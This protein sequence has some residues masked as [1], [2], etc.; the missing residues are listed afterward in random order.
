MSELI[1]V[2][3]PDE[4]RAAE[5]LQTLRRLQ[6]EGVIELDD[7][8]SA[9]RGRDGQLRL[10]QSHVLTAVSAAQ[11]ALWGG[12]LGLLVLAPLP[13]MVMGAAAGAATGEVKRMGIDGRFMRQLAQQLGPGSSAAFALVRRADPEAV[14]RELRPYGGT[15]LHTTLSEQDEARLRAGLAAP[16]ADAANPGESGAP[17][18]P[19]GPS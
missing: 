19:A 15:V 18:D 10:Q 14:L 13:G 17:G 4:G 5:V 11:G 8:A 3:Y 1:A 6:R 9:V 16:P 2:A 7:V 12:L